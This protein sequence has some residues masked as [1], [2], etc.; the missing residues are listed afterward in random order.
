MKILLYLFLLIISCNGT[1]KS[2]PTFNCIATFE[3]YYYSEKTG[4]ETS[5][6]TY[7]YNNMTQGECD[8]YNHYINADQP[9]HECSQNQAGQSADV[10]ECI[11]IKTTYAEENCSNYDTESNPSLP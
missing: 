3:H 1:I 6:D 5:I 9:Y 2:E 11:T 7:C 8:I 10:Q 4:P